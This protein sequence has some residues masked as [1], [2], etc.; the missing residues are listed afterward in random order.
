MDMPPIIETKG[1]RREF[2]AGEG[3]VAVLKDVDLTIHAGEMVAIVGAS[4]SGKS[5]LM[6]ILGCLDRP[7]SGSYRVQGRDT[8]ALAPDE[9]AA[10]RR[11]HFGFIFQRYHLLS[12]LSAVGNVEVPSIYAGRDPTAR[13]ERALALLT[14]LGL[15]ERTRHL[16]GQ[17]SGGQ[18]Q[19][20]SI[21][22]A[23]MN[24]GAII[25]ADEPTGALDKASG[26]EVMRILQELN[27]EGHTIILVTHDMA[28][29]GHADR[30]IEISDGVIVADRYTRVPSRPQ[31][32][33]EAPQP[34]AVA[35]RAAA[36]RFSEAFRMALLA[37][38]AHRMRTFLTMLGIII[39]IASVVSVVALGNGAQS[40]VMAQIS[41]LGTNTID[42]FPGMDFGDLRAASIQTL[43]EGDARVLA[44]QTYIDS[45]SPNVSTSVTARRDNIAA[46]A[47]I[48]GVGA[49]YFRVRGYK[50]AQGTLFKEAE[51]ARAA[52][53]AVIDTKA[54]TTLFPHGA[55]PIGATILLGQVPVRV[56]GV[57]RPSQSGGGGSGVNVYIPYSTATTRM[58][59][60]T[61]LE[62]ITVRVADRVTSGAAQEAVTTL[63]TRRHGTK[64]FF[65]F[66]SDQI[67]KAITQTSQTL[68]LLISSIAVI[69]LVVGGIGV[70]N[71]MLVS[72]TE[73]TR[74][75]GV[76][77]AVG[78]RQSDI[79][80]QFL[81]EA[82]LV[83]LI[84]GAVGVL[85][86]L[87]L[88]LV[89]RLTASGFEMVFSLPSILLAFA[90]STGIGILFGFLP[91]R[92]AARLDPV[93]ALA[94]D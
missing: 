37:M 15:G 11:E 66:N 44:R 58:T 7:T 34:P 41:D 28:V 1:L 81:I 2:P 54:R 84:G 25:L 27:A 57:L 63:L 56:I 69:A 38:A 89:V 91:A 33:A 36:D 35:W 4:G 65:I 73:R 88:G 62:S 16:P 19:R 94:R 71:I 32:L 8:G 49:G 43:S 20:V 31:V 30:V 59:G 12:D 50:V 29:A 46:T 90:C 85:L 78:A 77:M 10:L 17:L 80:Q 76:R 18:Q 22:R 67:R 64:D 40:K 53:V 6:N 79:L 55:N 21:A 92:N 93:E 82:V 68:T 70:M 86:A 39:G 75:I 9:L 51:V 52:Q 13:R 60:R 3:T 14:R 48:T 74:E 61:K 42:I 26:E 87:L 45:V 24:G 5:T 72:V 23:L 83:C 47:Q